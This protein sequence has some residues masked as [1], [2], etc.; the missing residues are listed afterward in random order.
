MFEWRLVCGS[1]FA[2]L[3]EYDGVW[4]MILGMGT[5]YN[6]TTTVLPLYIVSHDHDYDHDTK[7]W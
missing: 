3:S 7:R 5:L 6:C 1:I 4:D 2:A